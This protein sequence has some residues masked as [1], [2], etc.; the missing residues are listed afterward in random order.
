MSTDCRRDDIDKLYT[1]RQEYNSSPA[2]QNDN[3]LL[4]VEK[5][6]YRKDKKLN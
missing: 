1:S 4:G 3:M 6:D 2:F 5:Y